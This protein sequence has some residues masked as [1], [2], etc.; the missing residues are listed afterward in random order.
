[1]S[2]SGDN[3]V[4]P[5][6]TNDE[7]FG[8]FEMPEMNEATS[9]VST[10]NLNLNTTTTSSSVEDDTENRLKYLEEAVARL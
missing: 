9:E 6:I 2:S 8:E 4:S 7:R 10:N 5:C 1:M 3:E